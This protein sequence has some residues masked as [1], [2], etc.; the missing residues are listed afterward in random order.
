MR[1][2]H[3]GSRILVEGASPFLEADWLGCTNPAVLKQA[4][5]GRASDRK[6]RLFACACVGRL[7]HLLSE[8]GLHVLRAYESFSAGLAT[9]EALTAR[10]GP[11]PVP[12]EDAYAPD[13]DTPTGLASPDLLGEVV[14]SRNLGYYS[15]S[16]ARAAQAEHTVRRLVTLP[17]ADS[18]LLLRLALHAGQEAAEWVGRWAVDAE[19]KTQCN[20]LRDIFGNPFRSAQLR[21]EWLAHHDG[22]AVRMAR[23]IYEERTFADLPY[24]ADAL[25]EAG[26][27]DS[28]ILGHCREP[29]EHTRGCWV[30]DALLG[31][32]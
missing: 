22:V 16:D 9:I 15:P 27:D 19:R 8:H 4:L 18:G 10:L 12:D 23:T 2:P 31:N 7:S 14:P 24:L 5:D 32:K 25:E 30:V 28:S 26:C 13:A 21:P 6:S 1:C 29:G 17:T 3:T 11:R 20:L